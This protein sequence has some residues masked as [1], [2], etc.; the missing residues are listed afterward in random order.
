MIDIGFVSVDSDAVVASGNAIVT[1]NGGSYNGGSGASNTAVWAKENATIIINDGIFTVGSDA[2]GDYNDLIYAR[3]NANIIINGGLF[4]SKVPWSINGKYYVLN[5]KNDSNAAI[6]VYGGTFINYN[7]ADGDDV[8][9]N[10]I[11]VAE[12]CTVKSE[13]QDNGDIWYTVVSE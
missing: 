3:D 8:V 2:N 7:P 12:G 1:I 10:A 4:E 9:E 6:T 13:I 5:V 11:T